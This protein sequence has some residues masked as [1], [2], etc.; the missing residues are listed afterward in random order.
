MSTIPTQTIKIIE[1]SLLNYNPDNN[2]Y[3]EIGIDVNDLSKLLVRTEYLDPKTSKETLTFE[4]IF[5]DDI[6]TFR[7][8]DSITAARGPITA[9][10]GPITAARGPITAAR[11]PITAARGP[12]T[13]ARGPIGLQTAAEQYPQLA[14]QI[15]QTAAEQY[16]QLADQIL[17]TAAESDPATCG[18]IDAPIWHDSITAARGPIGIKKELM[19]WYR[20]NYVHHVALFDN[21]SNGGVYL[22]KFDLKPRY[23]KSGDTSK[24]MIG[25][26]SN[27]DHISISDLTDLITYMGQLKESNR[28]DETVTIRRYIIGI[29]D[30]IESFPRLKQMSIETEHMQKHLKDIN[31]LSTK[32]NDMCNKCKSDIVLWE[33]DV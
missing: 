31:V 28:I 3:T 23:L 22:S 16:P 29:D 20:G 13:A 17:Q 14:D 15:L 11:G 7:N 1:D 18:K 24:F 6:R 19:E 27:T 9:A 32:L 33:L 21:I 26:S 10:R 4:E 12:I 2:S 30:Y 25:F 8:M 5:Y